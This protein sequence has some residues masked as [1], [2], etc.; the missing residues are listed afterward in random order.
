MQKYPILYSFRRCPYAIR[1]RM[2]IKL[3]KITCELRE[4][5]LNNKPEQ[6][7][8]IS[9]KG[10]VPVLLLPDGK[11]IDESLDVMLWALKHSDP[12]N[13]L[14]VNNT[15]TIALINEYDFEF[16]VHLDHY[17]YHVRYPEKSQY[18]YRIC[19]EK[20]IKKLEKRLQQHSGKGLIIDRISLADVAIFPYVRQFA[21]VDW[22]WFSQSEYI[23]LKQWLE[24]FEAS[25]LFKS[26]MDKYNPWKETNRVILFG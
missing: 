14:Q 19:A 26:V 10:T 20:F 23:Q 1:A 2:A 15:E 3:A 4:V 8:A 6:M 18:Y 22:S 21:H 9:N 11:V 25:S 12:E 5:F 13:W 7:I 17:K 16:T 24:K